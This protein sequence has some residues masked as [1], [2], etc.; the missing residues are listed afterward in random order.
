M[1]EQVHIEDA[2]L[3]APF[4]FHEQK[5]MEDEFETAVA[6]CKQTG[7]GVIT[8]LKHHNF[9]YVSRSALQRRL[10]YIRSQTGKYNRNWFGDKRRLLT[11]DEESDLSDFIKE[12]GEVDCGVTR[13]DLQQ[14]IL[15]VLSLRKTKNKEGR[16]LVIPL[17][18]AARACLTNRHV[19]KKFIMDFY[20]RHTELKE[21]VPRDEDSARY[22]AACEPTV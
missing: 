4:Y 8:C 2:K 20:D 18:P 7:K 17:S 3:N 21:M 22:E 14:K 1:A 5:Q 10:K 6:W 16:R 11:L 15:L 9:S 13:E 12:G 19:S